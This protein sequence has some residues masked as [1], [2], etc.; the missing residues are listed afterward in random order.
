MRSAPK[1]DSLHTRIECKPGVKSA[2]SRILTLADGGPAVRLSP[3]SVIKP[4]AP[5]E[6]NGDKIST[7]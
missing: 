1:F 3:S 5:E 7:H 6:D 2:F 4:H